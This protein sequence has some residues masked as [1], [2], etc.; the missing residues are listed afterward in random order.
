MAKNYTT[1]QIT[2]VERVATELLAKNGKTT[3]LEIKNQLRAEGFWAIQSAVAVSMYVITELNGWHWV[4][5]GTY[6]TYYKDLN[7][8]EA[9]YLASTPGTIFETSWLG[10]LVPQVPAGTIDPDSKVDVT[11]LISPV[12]V[13]RPEKG[14]WLVFAYDGSTTSIYVRADL[15]SYEPTRTAVRTF[16]SREKG[17]A[18]ELVAAH[19]VSV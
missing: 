5:N 17:I 6:R 10:W 11:Q 13:N 16:Y 14:D 7:S 2:D 19:K 4:F 8:A 9:A 1:L 15:G 12:E 18:R 3:N